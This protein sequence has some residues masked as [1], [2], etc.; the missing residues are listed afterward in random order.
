M[1]EPHITFS[2]GKNWQAFQGSMRP[3]AVDEAM[4]DIREWLGPDGLRGKRVVDVGSGSGLSSLCFHRA[5]AEQVVSFDVDPASVEATARLWRAE[6]MPPSWR[7]SAASIL[8]PTLPDRIGVF[9]VVYSWGV[10]HHTGAMWSALDQV[11]KLVAPGGRLWITL[12]QKGPRYEEHLALKR[13]YNEGSAL[14]RSAMVTRLVAL[15][16]WVHVLRHKESPFTWNRGAGRGMNRYHDTID[17]LGGLP[18]EVAATA[19]V[20]A[21]CSERVLTSIRTKEADEGGCSGYLFSRG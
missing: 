21:A 10:L 13:R 4:R 6:G 3:D 20:V 1:T 9:D 5:G 15:S 8:D 18:Y 19:E 11:C 12:Y 16:L 2:F 7:V 14:R 17:W